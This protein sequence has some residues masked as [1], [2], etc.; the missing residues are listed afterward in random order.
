MGRR[1]QRD[2]IA[3][4]RQWDVECARSSM[5]FAGDLGIRYHQAANV[6][7]TSL[8]SFPMRWL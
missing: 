7:A 4:E 5:I 2:E 1:I 8:A 3:I 6:P